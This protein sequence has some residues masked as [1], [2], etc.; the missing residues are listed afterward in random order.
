MERALFALAL[1][2]LLGISPI[3]LSGSHMSKEQKQGQEQQKEKS[4]KEKKEEKKE[5]GKEQG[6]TPPAPSKGGK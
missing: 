3:A 4:A 1:A 2:G 6:A 5:Q